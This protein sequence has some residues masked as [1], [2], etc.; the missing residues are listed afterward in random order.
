MQTESAISTLYVDIKGPA[1]SP[2]IV[3]LHGGGGGGWMW[4]PHVARL[5]NFHCLV[6]DLPE[7][8]R[9]SQVKPFSISGAATLIADLIR[10]QAHGGVAHVVGLSEGAQITVEL[11]SSA[12]DVVSSAV[13]SSAS[14]RP[15]PGTSWLTPAVL[16]ATYYSSV[17]PLKNWDAWIRLNMKYAA[18]IPDQYFANF[19]RD[20]QSI[21]RDAWVNLMRANVTYR[22]P[23]GLDRVASPVLVVV[24][25]K[26]YP[27]M[28]QSARD[29]IANIPH[30]Q[31]YAVDLGK[32]ATLAEEHNWALSAPEIF[33]DMVRAWLEHSPL[34]PALVPL[35]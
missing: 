9:S 13:I 20:F 3:F 23:A 34:P 24:G 2:S 25:S 26:E 30:A 5:A 17:A 8:G 27:A 33:T 6:P 7:H 4:Q 1:D 31:G 28:H 15:I 18:G 14:L 32:R 12:P 22:L 11:L 29:L 35:Q 21:T 16:A 10:T 19:K